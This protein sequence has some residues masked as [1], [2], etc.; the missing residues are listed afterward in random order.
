[1]DADFS[2]YDG[3]EAVEILQQGEV[4]EADQAQA[5]T[6][7]QVYMEDPVL[8]KAR[9]KKSY[10]VM[11]L[12][13]VEQA[14]AHR[15]KKN[16]GETMLMR[17]LGKPNFPSIHDRY[18]DVTRK[19]TGEIEHNFFLSEATGEFI[20]FQNEEEFEEWLDAVKNQFTDDMKAKLTPHE[21]WVMHKHGDERAFTGE[22]WQT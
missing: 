18:L 11:G 17:Q 22:Y 5:L 1:M 14:D 4:E 6:R 7:D 12:Q 2:N 10:D 13:S 19:E 15:K 16:I 9:F 20:K 3:E 8:N 21:Y